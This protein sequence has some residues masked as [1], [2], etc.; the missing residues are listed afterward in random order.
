[1]TDNDRIILSV[2]GRVKCRRDYSLKE[3]LSMGTVE[4]TGQL[5]MACGSGEPKR[6]MEGCRGV[7]LTDII[8]GAEVLIEDHN[9]TKK[10]YVVVSSEDGYFTVFSWQELFNTS[11][12]EGAIVVLEA[13]GKKVR[14][15]DRS[16]DLISARD[17]LTGPRHV[18]QVKEVT[19]IMAELLS[20]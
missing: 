14:D 15:G 17:F 8:N 20:I 1:M 2:A 3:L 5:L 12:G 4:E 18:K 6:H 10:F 11:V 9:D 19:V 13:D 16:I 7:L